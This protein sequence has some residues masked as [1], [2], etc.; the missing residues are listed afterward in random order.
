MQQLF[1]NDLAQGLFQLGASK[2]HVL[3]K[4]GVDEGLVGPTAGFLDLSAKPIQNVVVQ[5]DRTRLSWSLFVARRSWR[6]AFR[7]EMIL[8]APSRR[9]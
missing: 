4:S 1:T 8:I 2:L 7:A 3:A 5:A 6:V 9:V